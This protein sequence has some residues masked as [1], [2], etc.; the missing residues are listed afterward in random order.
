MGFVYMPGSIGGVD[1]SAVTATAEDVLYKKII[2]DKNGTPITGTI[3]VNDSS[4]IYINAG[5][6]KAI[7]TGYYKNSKIIANPVSLNGTAYPAHVLNGDTFYSTD[8][9]TRLTG[10]MPNYMGTTM[11]I[12]YGH[13]LAEDGVL[14][15]DGNGYAH[16]DN[17][18]YYLGY[19]VLPG[20]YSTN[21][22]VAANVNYVGNAVYNKAPKYTIHGVN[23]YAYLRNANGA[24]IGRL[25]KNATLGMLK[26]KV[27]KTFS[28]LPGTYKLHVIAVYIRDDYT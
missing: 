13:E 3:P 24:D 8:A 5:E 6:T 2:V 14:F 16:L 7:S 1:N 11:K 12:R 23:D 17:G 15:M 21:S 25:N 10:T 9:S 27:S 18:E 22:W 28:G 19:N 20:A 4:S 26:T